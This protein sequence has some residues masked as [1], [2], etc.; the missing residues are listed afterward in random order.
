MADLSQV[1]EHAEVIGSDGQY[2]GTIDKTEN[3]QIKLS[4]NDP[5]AGGEHHLIPSEWVESIEGNTIRLNKSSQEVRQNWRGVQQQMSQPGDANDQ[6][7]ESGKETIGG[8]S[9]ASGGANNEQAGAMGGSSFSGTA[10]GAGR[11][12]ENY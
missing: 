11:D 12:L 1:K 4:K 10:S 7:V 6:M 9:T 8:S 5:A 2:V 3:N